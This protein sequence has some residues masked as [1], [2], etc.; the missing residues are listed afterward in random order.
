MKFEYGSTVIVSHYDMASIVQSA[1]IDRW[2]VMEKM[3][4]ALVS[5]TDDG[6]FRIELTAKEVAQEEEE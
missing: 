2:G 1:M 4:V 5:E 6:G 3:I